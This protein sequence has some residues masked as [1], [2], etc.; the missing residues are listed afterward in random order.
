MPTLKSATALMEQGQPQQQQ[1]PSGDVVKRLIAR[2]PYKDYGM[3]QD[4]RDGALVVTFPNGM[5]IR[6]QSK[7][8]EYYSQV[9]GGQVDHKDD[10]SAAMEKIRAAEESQD[11]RER[12]AKLKDLIRYFA[13][14]E[15]KQEKYSFTAYVLGQS[16]L[17]LEK[18]KAVYFAYA[19]EE[20]GQLAP[21]DRKIYEKAL[22]YALAYYKF[23]IGM[24]TVID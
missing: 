23:L 13:Q 2:F 9:A 11:L 14:L 20:P 21:D 1:Q 15:Y 6:V 5:K 22:A 8:V 12:T 17:P 4:G 19:G 18:I 7:A 24:L 16:K 3:A 10:Y